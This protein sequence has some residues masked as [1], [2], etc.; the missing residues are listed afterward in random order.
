M[1][2]MFS[3]ESMKAKEFSRFSSSLFFF[4]NELSLLP[5]SPLRHLQG[6]LGNVTLLLRLDFTQL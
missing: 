4:L 1:G 3:L 2:K 5:C 6:I